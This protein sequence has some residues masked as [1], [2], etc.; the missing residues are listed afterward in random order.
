MGDIP[1]AVQSAVQRRISEAM[2]RVHYRAGL[3][4]A[5]EDILTGLFSDESV[6]RATEAYESRPE[7]PA[8]GRMTYALAAAL[9]ARIVSDP[10]GTLSVVPLDDGILSSLA[11]GKGERA[12]GAARS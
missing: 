10:D 12:L 5:T 2:A 8:D 6:A 9:G 4:V 7:L 3:T 1:N 11:T